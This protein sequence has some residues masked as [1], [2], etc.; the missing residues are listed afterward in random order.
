VKKIKNG[1]V[2]RKGIIKFPLI[3]FDCDQ[4]FA[5]QHEVLFIFERDTTGKAFRLKANAKDFRNFTFALQSH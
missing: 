4:F 2:A 3:V 5:F 1:I